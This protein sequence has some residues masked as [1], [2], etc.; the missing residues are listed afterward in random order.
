LFD[1]TT[2]GEFSCGSGLFFDEG[3]KLAIFFGM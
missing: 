3:D 1:E 2:P